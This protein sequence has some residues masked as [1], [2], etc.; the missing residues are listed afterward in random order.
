MNPLANSDRIT[1][2]GVRDLGEQGSRDRT[3]RTEMS[4]GR[5]L[6]REVLFQL[7]DT[8]SIHYKALY[9]PAR[10]R[11]QDAKPSNRFTS[12][13][14]TNRITALSRIESPHTFIK[15]PS[16]DASCRT[17]N[18]DSALP[19]RLLAYPDIAPSSKCSLPPSCKGWKTPTQIGSLF[20]GSQ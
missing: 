13:N 7:F 1:R 14:G 8:D 10:P 3:A 6:F 5:I 19:C 9:M 2:I 17:P 18:S 11:R 16:R 15:L 4:G 12:S 20:P